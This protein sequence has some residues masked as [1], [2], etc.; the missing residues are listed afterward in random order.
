MIFFLNL[1]IIFILSAINLGFL[2]FFSVLNTTALLP[3]LF[4]IC[5]AYF[6]RGF[7]PFVIAIFAGVMTDVFS[8][9]F[10]G[11]YS[12]LFILA[13]ALIRVTFAEGM[14]DLPFLRYL[15][16]VLVVST[17]YYLMQVLVIFLEKIT[18]NYTSLLLPFVYLLAFNLLAAI[19][20]YYFSLWYFDKIKL[21]ENY[22]KRQ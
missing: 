18:I 11:F 15:L 6:R 4:I 17:F 20:V 12:I 14:K 10:F 21:I 19:F 2:P 16:M 13:V 9:Y 5:L 1:L 22:L 3:L 7:E 8:V